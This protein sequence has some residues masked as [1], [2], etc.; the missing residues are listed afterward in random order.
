MSATNSSINPVV[1]YIM[2]H[3]PIMMQADETTKQNIINTLSSFDCA[4]IST[5]RRLKRRAFID[6]MRELMILCANVSGKT[7]KMLVCE[8]VFTVMKNNIDELCSLF[9]EQQ[10]YYK[11]ASQQYLKIIEFQKEYSDG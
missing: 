6:R 3:D 8:A 4:I 9:P 5:E 1:D 2:D 11:L 10:E 7:N